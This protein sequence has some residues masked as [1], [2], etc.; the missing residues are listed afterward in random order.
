MHN[1]VTDHS[2][3][4]YSVRGLNRENKHTRSQKKIKPMYP[5]QMNNHP[6]K[7]ML[8]VVQ[9]ENNMSSINSNYNMPI[10]ATSN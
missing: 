6:S 3:D 5:N 1:Q 10:L 4:D 8:K 7:Q 2:D 9:E